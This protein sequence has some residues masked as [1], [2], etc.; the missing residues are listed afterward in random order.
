ML[1]TEPDALES[2]HQVVVKP[3][4][5]GRPQQLMLLVFS[6][7]TRISNIN[8]RRPSASSTSCCHEDY[9][10]SSEEYELQ[11]GSRQQSLDSPS[12]NTKLLSGRMN[13]CRENS[14]QQE[15][16]NQSRIRRRLGQHQADSS[17][18]LEQ[19]CHGHEEIRSGKNRRD[20]LFARMSCA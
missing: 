4:L 19:T 11:K 20:H 9:G 3:L 18:N 8:V 13:V 1:D 2:L 5:Q 17:G 6:S 10:R 14:Q 16:Q 7:R 15:A 12:G